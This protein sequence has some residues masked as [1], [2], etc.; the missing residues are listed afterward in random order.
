MITDVPLCVESKDHMRQLLADKDPAVVLNG[1]SAVNILAEPGTDKGRP[2]RI[3]A[4]L[5]AARVS[6]GQL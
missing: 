3:S 2:A 1:I 6:S 4:S 5:C